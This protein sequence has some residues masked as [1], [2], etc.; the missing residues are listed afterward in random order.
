[1][2]FVKT[3]LIRSYGVYFAARANSSG[4]L[5]KPHPSIVRVSARGSV[6]KP[7]ALRNRLSI[8]QRLSHKATHLLC[9]GTRVQEARNRICYHGPRY[10]LLYLGVKLLPLAFHHRQT[11]DTKAN[12]AEGFAPKVL[13]VNLVF[14]ASSGSPHN[15]TEWG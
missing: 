9:W 12:I 13:H 11:C 15:Y 8:T 4:H 6:A 2:D 7:K 10:R 5:G 14:G 3:A 1:M